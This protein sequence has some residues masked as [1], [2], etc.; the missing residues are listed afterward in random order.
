MGSLILPQIAENQAAA[1]VTSNDADALLEKALCNASS[2]HDAS[3]GDFVLSAALF[4]EHW[5]HSV[6][7]A[8]P[9]GFTITLPPVSRP[10]MIRNISGQTAILTT[11][12]GEAVAVVSGEAR[13]LYCD[14][15]NLFGLSD[16]SG[17]GGGAAAFSGSMVSLGANVSIPNS[18]V[19]ALPWITENHDT[20]SF[21]DTVVDPSRFTVPSG[22]STVILTAQ[23]RWDSNAVGDRQI[24]FQKNGSND[25]P[26]R[27]FQKTSGVTE[28]VQH[29]V[30]P[31][32]AVTGGDYFELAVWQ[33]SGGTRNIQM[34]DTTWFS[35]QVLT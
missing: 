13:M 27:P 8:A 28:A 17:G 20:D 24:L 34:H 11:G 23:V 6:G 1:Y 3:G 19:T 9:S 26:G 31:P 32:L 16:T 7:G 2:L 21:H 5:F 12:S 22:V 18:A 14:G 4:R 10:F 33:N 15:T 29:I 25:Y 30:S 35:V